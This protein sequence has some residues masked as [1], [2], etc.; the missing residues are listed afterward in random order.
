M[1]NII[2]YRE[3][4]KK[5]EKERINYHIIKSKLNRIFKYI[6]YLNNNIYNYRERIRREIER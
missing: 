6:K 3:R 2:M 4:E 1:C 5:R